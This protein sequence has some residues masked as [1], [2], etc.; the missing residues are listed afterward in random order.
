[1]SGALGEWGRIGVSLCDVTA[2]LNALIGIQQA[3]RD[4]ARTRLG[5]TVKVSLFDLA[6]EPM[7]VPHLQAPYGGTAPEFVG[8][9]HPAITSCGAFSC[10]DGRD[11]VI[12]IQNERERADFSREVLRDPG[13]LDDARCADNATRCAHREWVDGKVSAVFSRRARTEVIDRLT[14]AQTAYGSVNTV[15]DLIEH[16][17]LRTRPMPV[18]G[19][20]VQVP[21][22]PWRMEWDRAEF[23]SAP[24]LDEQGTAIRAE[25]T[26]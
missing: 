15:N 18:A 17:R 22:A 25:L 1:M 10:A 24:R 7:S 14:T 6:A 5:S 13:L 11:I 23:P 20:M 2:G 26:A 12:S 21:A 9:K 19:R 4:R 8:L 3:Q 16:P